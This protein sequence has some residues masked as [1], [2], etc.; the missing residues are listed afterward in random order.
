M[1]VARALAALSGASAALAQVTVYGQIPLGQTASTATFQTTTI[2]AAYNTT[3]L[4]VPEPPEVSEGISNEFVVQLAREA[5]AVPGISI[6]HEGASFY[7]FSIEMSVINQ[8]LG[9]N[10]S[11]IN[12]PFLNLMSNLEERAGSV[13]VRLGGNTQEYA[14]LVPQDHPDLEPGIS[15]SK[16]ESQSLGTTLTPAVIYT[17]E[18]FYTC[19]N[20]SSM[21]NVKWFYGI[22]FNDSVNWRLEIAEHGQEILGENL[23]GM[24]AGNEPDFYV[25]FGRRPEGYTPADY[26]REVGEL[27]DVLATNDRIPRKDILIGPS[28]SGQ[29]WQIEQVLETGFM[30]AHHE[31]MYG[32]TVEHYPHDNCQAMYGGPRERWIDPQNILPYYLNHDNV[33]ELVRPYNSPSLVAQQYD[34]PFMMFETNTASCGGFPGI[35]NSYVAAIWG[36]DYGLQMAYS[37]F[38]HAM[39]HIGGQNVFYNPF[40]APPT[41]MAAFNQWTVGPIFYS[42]LILAEAFGKSNTSRVADLRPNG[43]SVSTPAYAIYENDQINKVALFNYLSDPSGASDISVTLTV[44]GTVP[45]SVRVKYLLA[46]TV[47]ERDGITWAGQTFG[48]TF[49]AD[50]RLKGDLNVTSV[51]CNVAENTC[52]I[53]VPAPGFAL[54]FFNPDDEGVR[55]SQAESTFA[56]TVHLKS[57]NTATVDAAALATSNGHSGKERAAMMGGT[58]LGFRKNAASG[59]GERVRSAVVG[60]LVVAVGIWAGLNLVL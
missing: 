8:V 50:G 29:V 44:D 34:L 14:A 42:A 40:T 12:V 46:E 24:Q 41:E 54:V 11:F 60:G 55:V 20:I 52:R 53:H 47:I 57:H 25:Q 5:G 22:P 2:R 56:T 27:I 7:G 21:V 13:V 33:V 26:N 59:M 39:L 9:K 16:A 15:Y 31:H 43:G 37:N 32:M 19:A 58:S 4:N 18:M 38:T 3:R 36:L 30:E 48:N 23:I 51:D 6:P 35:S 1:I 17:M 10:S 49:E 45:S 28:T